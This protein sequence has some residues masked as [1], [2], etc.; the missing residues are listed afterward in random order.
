MNRHVITSSLP[1]PN[2]VTLLICC[3]LILLRLFT[4]A[5][6]LTSDPKTYDFPRQ[7]I[8][9]PASKTFTLNNATATPIDIS[10]L[11]IR[12]DQAAEFV[13]TLE[14]GSQIDA[15][16]SLSFEIQFTPTED[17]PNIR[18]ALLEIEHSGDDMPLQIPLTGEAFDPTP[19]GGA[20]CINAGGPARL[21]N[22]V[23]WLQ[24]QYFSGGLT[25]TRVNPIAGTENDVIFNSHR[26]GNME[27]HIPVGAISAD[28]FE[29]ELNFA[30]LYHADSGNRVFGVILEGDTVISS[31]DLVDE[32]GQNTA[33]V[34]R[35]P[36]P[37]PQDDT[38]SIQFVKIVEAPILNGIKVVPQGDASSHNQAP[39]ADFS[40]QLVQPS[41]TVAFD[42]SPSVD[43]DGSI[44]RYGWDF[45]DGVLDSGLQVTH[46]Y[47]SPG[48]YSVSLLVTDNNG[49]T[50]TATKE[51]EVFSFTDTSA[52]FINAGGPAVVSN[53]YLWMKDQYVE[54]GLEFMQEDPISDTEDDVIFQTHRYGNFSYQI[55]VSD[56]NSDSLVV[57][58]HF[59][60]LFYTEAGKR[61]FGIQLEGNTLLDSLDI[62]AEVGP[63]A[64]LILPYSLKKPI[65]DTVNIDF[66]PFIE[67]PIVNGIK[68]IP[69][70]SQSV[71]SLPIADFSFSEGNEALIIDF[72]AS[73]SSDPDGNIVSYEWDLGDGNTSTGVSLSHTYDNPGTFSVKLT[74]TD[75]EGG[76]NSIIKEVTVQSPN[77]PPTAS[78]T[79]EAGN[80]TFE[81][82]F[83]A[84]GSSDPEGNIVSYSWDFGDGNTGMGEMISHV[85]DSAGVFS[86]SLTVTDD[87]GLADSVSQN[88]GLESPNQPPIASFTYREGATLLVYEFDA[89]SS[90]DPD[91]TIV[92]YQWD[93]GD[94]TALNGI[95]VSHMYTTGGSF[96]VQLIVTDNGGAMDTTTQIVMVEAPNQAPVARFSVRSGPD[97]LSVVLK[98][99]ES[100][101]PDGTIQSYQW[102]LG[103]GNL[104]SGEEVTHT[105]GQVSAFV[106]M[107]VVTDN[108][109]GK[110]SIQQ[111]FSLPEPD[112][113][114]NAL[115]INAGGDELSLNGSLWQKD[116]FYI[117]GEV[118]NFDGEIVN[119]LMD[120]LYQSSRSGNIHYRIPLSSI[121]AQDYVVTLYFAETENFTTGERVF[122]VLLDD[123]LALD[124]YDIVGEGGKLRETIAS[125]D[126]NSA[127]TDTL[128]L[129]FQAIAGS[130]TLSAIR[131]WGKTSTQHSP[132]LE[133]KLRVQVFPNPA[134]VRSVVFLKLN[135]PNP[136]SLRMRLINLQ[137]QELFTLPETYIH[138]LQQLEIPTYSLSSGVYQI[139]L[140]SSDGG[141]LT[142]SLI[143][144]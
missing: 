124:Q 142:R 28:S 125:I 35:Y 111:G 76:K 56:F 60:E 105:Y 117:S 136:L 70:S 107:L 69:L 108:E 119:T 22:G 97:A 102:K 130:P 93:M 6:G 4:Q 53:D 110:D 3:G 19:V 17:A 78:F 86:V 74:I 10:Q 112:T 12:G 26:F 54:G 127:G 91:G 73:T 7:Q 62:V 43:L 50:H 79:F 138:G 94:G 82:N 118:S 21:V 63:D 104:A 39:V 51:L 100:F 72:D 45:G 106:A 123:S 141:V 122:N 1:I 37:I 144:Q 57:E 33:W 114:S 41:Q 132:S 131:V 5:Q 84:S 77:Q 139:L 67:S 121:P 25:F 32:V 83:D 23:V 98:A 90:S 129:K 42:A 68:L 36:L 52:I 113:L 34:R 8:N 65:N 80:D 87:Q 103:D 66:I 18:R 2:V 134:V 92:D 115:R 89:S 126:V 30:E 47:A 109:G 9:T 64:A 49:A 15:Q 81:I 59:A 46:T 96:D 58:F 38:I 75:N 61:K 133:D 13:S 44:E 88:I 55:P 27:Y 16:G 101:D 135:A 71:N 137:G 143:V 11:T 120:E 116:Q 20:L 40:F 95:Q 99:G 31:V 85:Y 128:D 24:D 14:P 48:L 29:V 140:E